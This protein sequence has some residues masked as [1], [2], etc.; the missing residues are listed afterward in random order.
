MK[1]CRVCQNEFDD[2]ATHCELDGSPLEAS[3]DGSFEEDRDARPLSNL[4]G[5]EAPFEIE[6][7]L[8]LAISISDAVEHLHSE[9]QRACSL[10]PQD[11]LIS[12]RGETYETVREIKLKAP[13]AGE[14]ALESASVYSAP[15]T[16][17]QQPSDA[18]SD[19]YSIGA[20]LYEMLTG[21]PTFM[22]VSPA[23]IIIKKSL[24][25]PRPL[26]DLR[27]DIPDRVQQIVASAIDKEKSARQQSALRLKQ[28][29]EEALAEFR[30]RSEAAAAP[31]PVAVE[32]PHSSP[33][34]SAPRAFMAA[35]VESIETAKAPGASRR[36]I[37]ATLIGATVL[38]GTLAAVTM[39]Q[40]E[41]PSDTAS[42]PS[43][44]VSS[45]GGNANATGQSDADS[46]VEN[47][48]GNGNANSSGGDSVA[49]R[50]QPKPQPKRSRPKAR[51][52]ETP[53]PKTKPDKQDNANREQPAE[54]ASEPA[55]TDNAN[56]PRSNPPPTPAPE[57]ERT[58]PDEARPRGAG[59]KRRAR[60]S[61]RETPKT[62]PADAGESRPQPTPKPTRPPE[63]SDTIAAAPPEPRPEKREQPP[64]RTG[65]S[66]PARPQNEPSQP[67]DA[68]NNQPTDANN[69]QPD[70]AQT[71]PPDSENTNEAGAI[72]NTESQPPAE[73][74]ISTLAI[75]S[76]AILAA[77]ALLAFIL[78]QRR[79]RNTERVDRDVSST[80]TSRRQEDTEKDRRVAASPPPRVSPSAPPAASRSGATRGAAAGLL[81]QKSRDEEETVKISSERGAHAQKAIKRCPSCETEFSI[82]VRFCVYDG[83]PLKEEVKDLP[84][85][86]EP[87]FYDL[88]SLETRKR[89]PACGAEYA[90][91]KKFCRFDGQ[92]LVTW[93]AGAQPAKP[94][95]SMEPFM[96]AQYRCFARLGEGGMGVVYKARDV[97][98]DRLAA[99]KVLLPQTA[100]LPDAS[101]RFRREAQL[102][103]SIN[104]PNCVTIYGYGEASAKLFYMAMEFIAGISLSQIVHP[105][106]LSPRP[107]PLARVLN[108]T[109]QICEVLDAAHNAGIV[110]RDLKP[111]NVMICERP[112]RSDMVK[113]VDFGIARSLIHRGEYETLSGTLT[114]TPAYMSPEQARTEPDVDARS[115][116]FS[117]A[118]MV[119]EMMSGNLPF[120]GKGLNAWQQIMQ[121]AT[122]EAMPPPLSRSRPDLDIPATVDEVLARALAPDRNR[123][124]RS[125]PQF[126]EELERAVGSGHAAR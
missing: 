114:G 10:R 44:N 36:L 75:V 113:V 37:L 78:L 56:S 115:D 24:E 71:A 118:V 46:S 21:Q 2:S 94:A 66:R 43:E 108:I 55:K 92:Q 88:Q 9:G 110:H 11:I 65:R 19:V 68:N 53:S 72:Q 102:A 122:L 86:K 119:Y 35:S 104:H 79:R 121:R 109:R 23:A 125:A 26:T 14:K 47:T 105:R 90:M 30:K 27:P 48:N 17:E 106:S 38:L 29:L 101:K 67:T 54:P 123:R 126:I 89:C 91:Q 77:G 98:L 100:N 1:R 112:D 70:A 73:S 41:S 42:L 33:S 63:P 13:P 8:Q 59:V 80:T 85:E 97:D 32:A 93:A 20:I 64:A 81:I 117:L 95:E 50:S 96:V 120:P 34:P 40:S 76:A 60:P 39:L 45:S 124:T 25:R 58:A 62:E 31:L 49:N 15:E 16:D 83:T 116:L 61:P 103:S 3:S 107:L 28:E 51:R 4:I 57:P 52:S 22:A 74:N 82:S 87:S 18:A 7:A 12:G 99:V 69:N 111:Q 84:D 5:L 6:R